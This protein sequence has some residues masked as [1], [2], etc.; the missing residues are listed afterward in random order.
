MTRNIASSLAF[1]TAVAAAAVAATILS[2]NAFADDITIDKTPFISSLT[3]AEVSTQLKVPYVGG[4]PW[5][6]KYDMFQIG[7]TDTS[8]QVQSQYKMSRDEVGALTGEDSGSAYFKRAPARNA[9]AVMGGPA[10]NF[11]VDRST[12]WNVE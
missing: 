6:G 12:P 4:N 10:A 3:R 9:S 2:R 8:E 7:S 11:Y 5:A 1:A